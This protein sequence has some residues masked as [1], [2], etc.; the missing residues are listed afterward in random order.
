MKCYFGSV[1]LK[2]LNNAIFSKT[3]VA[4]YAMNLSFSLL[5]I[6]KH[7]PCLLSLYF[8]S[9]LLTSARTASVFFLIKTR[10]LLYIRSAASHMWNLILVNWITVHFQS[11]TKQDAVCNINYTTAILFWIFYDLNFETQVL[12][13][14]CTC[15]CIQIPCSWIQILRRKLI[16]NVKK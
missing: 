1:I 12:L 14:I 7:T 15:K 13:Y 2:Y 8:S 5:V 4:M 3:L 16:N 10:I 9:Y 6:Y 11:R